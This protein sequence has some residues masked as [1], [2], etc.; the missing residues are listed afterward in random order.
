[1]KKKFIIFHY[2][3]YNCKYNKSRKKEKKKKKFLEILISRKRD[4]E[5]IYFRENI[6]DITNFT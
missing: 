5:K 1:M 2:S 3:L 6:Y 4:F